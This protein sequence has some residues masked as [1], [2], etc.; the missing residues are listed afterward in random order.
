MGGTF[1]VAYSK[2]F[3][4]EPLATLLIIVAIER[5]IAL[6]PTASGVAAAAAV[7]TRPQ[8][9]AFAPILMWRIKVHGGW[10]GLMKCTVPLIVALLVTASYNVLRFGDPLNFGYSDYP[11]GFTTPF[12]EGAAGLLF[13]P[14]KS[15]ILFAPIVVLIPFGLVRLWIRHRTGFWLLTGNLVLTFTIA[16]KWWAWGGGFMWGPRQLIAAVIPAVAAVGL[17]REPKSK[18]G[19]ILVCALFVL[20]AVVNFSALLVGAGAQ[21]ADQPP[22]RFGP[23]PFRQFT[24]ALAAMTLQGTEPSIW[25]VKAMHLISGRVGLLLTTAISVVLASGAALSVYQIYRS[26]Q[27]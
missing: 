12:L 1:L 24:L 15:V 11:Q 9:F 20:G 8:F 5:A 10:R 17:W 14:E 25:Q 21:L 16:A 3:C 4:S 22:P 6:S 27:D 13:H 18:F 23:D 26:V 19:G 2:F 7:L